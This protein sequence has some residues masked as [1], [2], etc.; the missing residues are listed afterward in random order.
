LLFLMHLIS[1][2]ETYDPQNFGSPLPR[3]E[4]VGEAPRRTHRIDPETDR[5]CSP[6][7]AGSGEAK[8]GDY[9][10]ESD[11]WKPSSRCRPTCFYNTGIATLRVDSDPNK[12]K[13]ERKGKVQLINGVGNSVIQKD[14]ALA[15]SARDWRR[16]DVKLIH[17]NL[18]HFEAIESYR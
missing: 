6:A 13:R 9:I 10:L 17:A 14:C 11:C 2:C 7:G 12:K 18:R 8:S 15:A 3:G 4:G 16:R 1:R 5:R